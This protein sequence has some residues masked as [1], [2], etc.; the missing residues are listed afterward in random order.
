MRPLLVLALAASACRFSAPSEVADAPIDTPPDTPVMPDVR[1]TAVEVTPQAI[2]PGMY[3][4]AVTATLHNGST[5]AITGLRASLA[6][7]AGGTDRAADF[8]W[9]DADARDRV[10][11]AQPDRLGPGADATFQFRLDVLA[12]AAAEPVLVS[13]TAQF[14]L[15]GTAYAALPLDPPLMLAFEALPPPII[16]DTVNDED[17]GNM[18]T[19]LREALDKASANPGFDRIVFDPAVFPPDTPTTI[20]IDTSRDQLPPITDFLVID[21]GRSKVTLAVDPSWALP[22]GRSGLRVMSG[23]A[24]IHGLAFRNFAYGYPEE[25][26]STDNCGTG[27]KWPGGAIAVI[28]GTLIL[29]GNE[30]LDPDVT[31]RNCYGASVR[32]AGGSGHRI[33]GNH[34]TQQV[35][36]SIQVAAPAIEVT[37]NVMDA[38]TTPAELAKADD[39]IFVETAQDDSDLW[40]IGNLCVD[41]EY[42]AVAAAGSGGNGVVHVVN[43]TFVRNGRTGLAAVRREGGEHR[44]IDLHNNAYH[45]NMPSAILTTD[46]MGAGLTISHETAFP[47]QFCMG[48]DGAT[49]DDGTVDNG[50]DLAFMNAAG[51]TRAALTPRS[52]SRLVDTGVDL[53]DRNGSAPGRYNG[54]RPE[55]GAVELP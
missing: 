5:S 8:R 51:I 4:L 1:F 19:S 14:L 13:G 34:W 47:N 30:L 18:R 36:D 40:I 50:L 44:R 28:D 42:S 39:C 41:Q 24:V 49:V 2:R 43:N 48:C 55:R 38:G 11:E 22:A 29:D 16:V 46:G 52:G 26:L 23:T 3:G 54:A 53:V 7:S 31:E 27:I 21:G 15:A 10:M 35:M 37:D 6:F 20:S 12:G 33:I 25:D 9:R 17:N 32:I 45:A